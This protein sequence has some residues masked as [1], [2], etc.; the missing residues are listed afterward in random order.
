MAERSEALPLVARIR[1][2][3][4]FERVKREGLWSRGRLFDVI[5]AAGRGECSRLGLII[6][7]HSHTIVERNRLKRRTR[8]VARRFLL[9]RL[10]SI[11]DLVVR[12]RKEAYQAD[13]ES[14]KRE[15]ENHLRKGG[16]K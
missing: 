7:L 14:L 16:G 2:H 10:E 5:T 11:S 3:E 4:E 13:F 6:P 15:L 8:E 1:K 12:A 9:P